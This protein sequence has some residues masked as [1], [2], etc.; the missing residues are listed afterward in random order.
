MFDL[1]SKYKVTSP[2]QLR[3]DSKNKTND[4]DLSFGSLLDIVDK[5]WKVVKDIFSSES[6]TAIV[7]RITRFGFSEFE[8][9]TSIGMYK[10]V[11]EEY[12]DL[13]REQI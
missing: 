13:L 5:T 2:S 6:K 9:N 3:D 4:T 10:G 11:P 12:F 1:I 8:S 7:Q